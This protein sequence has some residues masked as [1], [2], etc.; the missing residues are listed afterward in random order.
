M[1]APNFTAYLNQ[2]SNAMKFNESKT[3]SLSLKN[4]AF[5]FLLGGVLLSSCKSAQVAFSPELNATAMPVKGRQGFQI[6]QVIRYGDYR[7]D[8][9]RRGWT[10]SYDVPFIL[11]FQGAQEK[12]S[13][14]QFSPEGRA[15]R[16]SCV[17]RFKSNDL[18]LVQDFFSIPLQYENYFA[19]TLLTAQEDTWDFVLYNPNGDF[20]RQKES[21]GYARN[22]AQTI[23]IKAVRGLENQP[24]WLKKM[25]VYGHEFVLNGKVVGAVSTLNNGTVWI[26]PSLDAE[27]RT[28]LAALATGILL[29]TDVEVV[30]TNS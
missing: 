30:E 12:L 15:V 10:R 8:K 22:Y 28:I 24:E 4:Y 21:A 6:G 5:V 13:F 17:S 26:D 1:I 23:E 9:V 11:R 3:F 7:T 19:G 2:N 27:T 29:R 25:A 20:L 14:T 18:S 16:V